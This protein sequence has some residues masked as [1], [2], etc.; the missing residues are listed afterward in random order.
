MDSHRSLFHPVSEGPIRSPRNSSPPR[1]FV[2][3]HGGARAERENIPRWSWAGHP[4]A[5]QLVIS[6][7]RYSPRGLSLISSFARAEV[8]TID[9]AQH[10]GLERRKERAKNGKSWSQRESSLSRGR[11]F[12]VLSRRFECGQ[13]AV[14]QPTRSRESGCCADWVADWTAAGERL[15]SRSLMPTSVRPCQHVS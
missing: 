15:L 5:S 4:G 2:E 10:S 9:W 7:I 13:V 6:L 3:T 8:S 1:S 11:G 14:F 12:A